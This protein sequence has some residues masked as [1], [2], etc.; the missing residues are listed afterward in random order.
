MWAVIGRF[1]FVEADNDEVLSRTAKAISDGAEQIPGHVATQ[2]FVTPDRSE[3]LCATTY[4]IESSARTYYRVVDEQ[5][6]QL[7]TGYHADDVDFTFLEEVASFDG[8]TAG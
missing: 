7:R 8:K 4:E 6:E 1:G 2:V 5:R 3:L